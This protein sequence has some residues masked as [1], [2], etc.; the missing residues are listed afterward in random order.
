MLGIN[1]NEN[2][3]ENNNILFGK[4]EGSRITKRGFGVCFSEKS[5]KR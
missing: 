3:Q 1:V 2:K 5:K 4:L